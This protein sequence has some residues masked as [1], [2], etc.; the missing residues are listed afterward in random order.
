MFYDLHPDQCKKHAVSLINAAEIPEDLPA[1]RLGGLVPHAGWVYSGRLAAMTLRALLEGAGQIRTAVLFGA[2]HTGAVRSGEVYDSGAW[3]TPLGPVSVDAEL[4]AEL[5]SAS[6]LLRS[7][8]SAHASEHSLEVQVP[9]LQVMR[10]DVTILPIAVPPAPCAVQIG[11]AVGAVLAQ[12][13][14]RSA[15]VIGSTDLTHHGGHFGSP[16]GSGPRSESFSAQNDKR[17]LDIIEG[18]RAEDVIEEA[19]YSRNACGAGAIAATIAAV[20]T[21]GASEARILEYTNSYRIVHDQNPSDPDDTT[22]GYVSVV[23]F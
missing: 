15:C 13:R 21:M 5:I 9:L 18:M 17:L 10:P 1:P 3:D 6:D 2:D 7:N 20:S 16:G 23:F 19:H 8:P 4:G 14:A 12:S 22:V 11:Q